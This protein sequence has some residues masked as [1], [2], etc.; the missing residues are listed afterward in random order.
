MAVVSVALIRL[1]RK[2]PFVDRRPAVL[3]FHATA[4]EVKLGLRIDNFHLPQGLAVDAFEIIHAAV[5]VAE[6]FLEAGPGHEHPALLRVDTVQPLRKPG[7]DI[8]RHG[9]VRK[10]RH[11]DLIERDSV[12]HQALEVPLRELHRRRF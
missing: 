4:I 7:V 8:E 6:V 9:V 3:E 12:F 2:Q 10:S 1:E 11:G 5:A